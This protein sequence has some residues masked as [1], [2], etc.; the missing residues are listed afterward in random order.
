MTQT[1]HETAST[2]LTTAFRT[3]APP[4]IKATAIQKIRSALRI[5][6]GE[7]STAARI[8]QVSR[9]TLYRLLRRPELADALNDSR[10]PEHRSTVE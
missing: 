4:E 6:R 10:E 8:L 5:A 3:N 1:R 2:W 9:S 7:A